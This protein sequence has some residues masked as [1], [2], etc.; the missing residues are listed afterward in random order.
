M[1]SRQVVFVPQLARRMPDPVIAGAQRHILM[2]RAADVPRDIPLDPNPREQ[3][4]DRRVYRDVLESLMNAGDVEPNTFHLKNKGITAI[5]AAVRGGDDRLIVTFDEG[6]GIVDGGHTYR[7]IQRG[8]DSEELPDEQFVKFEI[9]VGV[10]SALVADIAGG[11]NTAV[12]VQEMSLANLEGKF[13][14]IQKRLAGEPYESVI[15]YKENEPDKMLDVRDVVAFMT[16]FNIELY[17]ND[18]AEYPITAYRAKVTALQQYLAKPDSFMRLSPILPDILRLSDLISFESRQLHNEAGGKGGKLAFM[19]HKARGQYD[20]PFIGKKSEYRLDNGAL[21][22]ML[23]A[24]RWMVEEG[25]DGKFRWKGTFEDVK[26]T[27]N[28]AGAELMRATQA[29]SN[30][31]SRNS[32][33][34]GKSRNHWATLHSIVIKHQLMSAAQPRK[35]A[36]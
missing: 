5:A 11:L 35:R 10:P 24:F 4:I 7:I 36:R 30:E 33:A 18:G 19:A 28:E 9:L 2:V 26:V 34:I 14:W 27:W 6:Q 13:D 21:Y 12:Q 3:N 16:L 25:P 32:N 8:Q 31:F 1:G 20:F 15:G 29:T 23:G 22:P 17:P